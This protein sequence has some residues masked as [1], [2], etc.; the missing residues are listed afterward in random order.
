MPSFFPEPGFYVKVLVAAVAATKTPPP[1]FFNKLT[2]ID[3]G[4]LCKTWSNPSA[5]V[6]YFCLL[7]QPLAGRLTARRYEAATGITIDKHSSVCDSN[8]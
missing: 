4:K 5:T 7:T 6:P 8:N 2:N 3:C 1:Y